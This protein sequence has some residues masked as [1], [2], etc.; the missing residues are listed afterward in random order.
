MI[1]TTSWD[2]GNK[3]DLKLSKILLENGIKGTFYIPI[4]W[5]FRSLSNQE[6]KKLSKNF[7]IG[8][9]SLSHSDL[10]KSSS[11]QLNHEI[12]K[13]KNELQE[14]IGKEVNSFAYPFGKINGRILDSVK[15][16]YLFARTTKEL[17]INFPTNLLK[18]GLSISVTNKPRRVFL[19]SGIFGL[20]NG[21]KW[22]KIARKLFLTARKN[23]GVFHLQGH[24]WEIEKEGN[25][26]SL[27]DFLEYASRIKNV[28]FLTNYEIL[29]FR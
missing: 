16:H 28:E 27:V 8:S 15:G 7:E 29:E 25:W 10:T 17:E 1:F 20:R 21:F 24:S 23:D 19:S 14:I 22:D 12:L 13:S 4:S 5:K 11:R 6:V 3:L 18:S 2:D 9:H 26:D